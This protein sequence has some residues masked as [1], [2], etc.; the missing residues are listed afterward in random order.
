MQTSV[1][2]KPNRPRYSA[3]LWILLA[4]LWVVC[5]AQAAERYQQRD[6]TPVIDL[7]DQNLRFPDDIDSAERLVKNSKVFREPTINKASIRWDIV[8]KEQPDQRLGY[9]VWRASSAE[10]VGRQVAGGVLDMV[11]LDIRRD[12]SDLL[13]AGGELLVQTQDTLPEE[14]RSITYKKPSPFETQSLGYVALG[15]LALLT[16][17]AGSLRRSQRSPVLEWKM[18]AN[19][20]LQAGVQ[21]SIFVYWGLYDDNVLWYA[22]YLIMQVLF[23]YV[24]DAILALTFEG[25]WR[26][27]AG[28]MPVVLSIN[29]FAWYLTPWKAAL[30]ITM[31][32][33]SKYL[34]RHKDGQVIFNPSGVALAFMSIT[35]IL[36]PQT[37][38]YNG[39]IHHLSLPPN[40]V[41]WIV[42]IAMIPQRRFPL[43]LVSLGCVGG[44]LFARQWIHQSPG[45]VLPATV[46]AFTL[47]VTEPRTMSK[48]GIGRLI[49]GLLF[50][51]LMVASSELFQQ[52]N[53][54][55]DFAKV[56]PLPFVNL[57]VR[58]V[59]ALVK[60][61][62]KWF[63]F[64]L[65]PRF[66][67]AHMVAFVAT[68]VW[69]LNGEKAMT[70]Q[71][72]DHWINQTPIIEQQPMQ[73]ARCSDNPAFCT[74]FGFGYE[75]LAWS[76]ALRD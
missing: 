60:K 66:N 59:D 62:P 37:W 29:L 5:S 10:P 75:V 58:P 57:V 13:I 35:F 28:P 64:L 41:E 46:L 18:K 24:V 48:T 2:P 34:L 14:L 40:M 23:A 76:R 54:A 50:G 47:L 65:E 9:L 30:V 70:F 26:M 43:V 68:M 22:P 74:P 25:K 42:L 1:N 61:L 17:M 69:A 73:S 67:T 27:G 32:L 31:A 7:L 8:D 63:G 21:S 33:A 45:I 44:L 49:Q 53:L 6:I 11:R 15:L 52:L 36:A 16:I 56:L 55:D 39:V 38:S 4:Q 3:W 20:F 51:G 71:P 19:H 72:H 12:T